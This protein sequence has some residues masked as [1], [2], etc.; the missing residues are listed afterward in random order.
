MREILMEIELLYNKMEEVNR[1]VEIE[2]GNDELPF[3]KVL[4]ALL[5]GL[6]K[7]ELFNMTNQELISH[8]QKIQI[9]ES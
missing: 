5:N 9:I 2:N 7:K 3:G 8:I 6:D 4:F 1:E